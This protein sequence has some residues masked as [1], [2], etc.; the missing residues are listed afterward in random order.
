MKTYAFQTKDNFRIDI[1]A[2][3]PQSAYNKLKSIPIYSDLITEYYFQ[4]DKDGYHNFSL[5]W[6]HLQTKQKGQ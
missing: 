6:K 5:G 2:T 3:T 1:K 4:Y